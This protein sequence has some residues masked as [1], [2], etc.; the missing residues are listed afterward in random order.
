MVHIIMNSSSEMTNSAMATGNIVLI[1]DKT[2]SWKLGTFAQRFD[3][4]T[5][6]SLYK[7]LEAENSDIITVIPA[8]VDGSIERVVAIGI[9]KNLLYNKGTLNNKYLA[10]RG[11]H[12]FKFLENHKAKKWTLIDD[13]QVASELPYQITLGFQTK[14]YSNRTYFSASSNIPRLAIY[15]DN[16]IEIHQFELDALS[17]GIALT[18]HL[19]STPSNEL[20]PKPYA[21]IIKNELA[22]LCVNVTILDRERLRTLGMGCLL[23]VANGSSA[24]PAVVIMELNP[25]SA[26]PAIGLV[27]KGVTF[28]SGGLSI[29]P[30]DSM[31]TMKSDMAGSAAIVGAIKSLAIAKSKAHV[32]GIVGLVE[33]MING[34]ALRPGDVLVS[35]SKQTVEVLNTDAEGRL[36]L[37]DLLHYAQDTLGCKEIIDI[38][39]LTG[40]ITVSL[41]HEYA[42][43][44]SNDDQLAQKLCNAGY[45]AGEHLYQLPLDPAYGESLNSGI[46]DMSN[47]PAKSIGAGSIV[48]AA[49]LQKYIK[50]N[51][52]WAHID[53]AGTAYDSNNPLSTNSGTIGYGVKLLYHYIESLSEQSKVIQ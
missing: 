14:S 53:I 41:G 29:K 34:N 45:K 46:A 33:N 26:H 38:A 43:L 51:T 35:M 24:D 8:P 1:L 25:D 44:F 20:L 2:D 17:S 47:I 52:K 19:V 50:S 28:D 39:T 11:A 13:L 9:S 4:K 10:Q 15:S 27:G 5:N 16:Q 6:G 36:V 21:E 23:G 42:G 12:L 30:S 40:A 49:F 7:A 3:N 18:K 37:C 48:A 22:D 31:I 32:I